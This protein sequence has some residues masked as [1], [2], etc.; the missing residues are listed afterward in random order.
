MIRK[1]LTTAAVVVALGTLFFG[2]DAWSYLSTI[3]S[4]V[5]Q[6]VRQQV[7][8][9]FELR[10]ARKMLADLEPV[11]RENRRRIAQE[12]VRLEQ[13]VQRIA[14][15][16]QKLRQGQAEILMLRDDLA[17]GK[18]HYTYAGRTYSAQEVREDLQRRF[19]RYKTNRSTLEHLR[20]V[21]R[22]RQK[23][24]QGLQKQ[25]Q[26]MIAARSQLRLEIENL[27][28]QLEM[29]RAAET[30]NQF[31]IDDSHLSR[32]KTLVRE[33]QQRIEVAARLADQENDAYEEIPVHQRG[34]A[35]DIVEEVTRYFQQDS[36]PAGQ[37][38]EG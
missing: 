33:L 21:Y 14:R 16:E 23:S 30:M 24:L 31:Q 3:V 32:L 5:R 38:G 6:Q 19:Q 25:L 1:V 8:T 9:E 20:Q 28:A 4:D 18:P 35:P 13:L 27:A 26:G 34:D 36:T 22:A 37:E 29:V 10:R 15:L 11:I 7:P 2:R 17:Q 12:Q